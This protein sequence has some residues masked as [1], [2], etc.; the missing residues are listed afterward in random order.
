MFGFKRPQAR[1]VEDGEA[2]VAKIESVRVADDGRIGFLVAYAFDG[3]RRTGLLPCA[4]LPAGGDLVAAGRL[5]RLM[6]IDDGGFII[7]VEPLAATR[8]AVA[9]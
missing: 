4:P 3:G 6:T 1:Y 8:R 2:V 7:A 9:A 5:L